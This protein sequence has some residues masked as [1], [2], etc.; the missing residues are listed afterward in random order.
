M[1]CFWK[2]I[3]VFTLIYLIS[4]INNKP[5]KSPIWFDCPAERWEES[6]P[7]GNGRI[8]MMLYGGVFEEKIVLN[9]ITMW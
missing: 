1:G 2:T 3:F 9:D 4:N 6:L 8:G 5:S 7:L